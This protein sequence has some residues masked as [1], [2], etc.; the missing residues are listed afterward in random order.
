MG[1]TNKITTQPNGINASNALSILASVRQRL[2]TDP[3][4]R[5]ADVND[6]IAVYNSW[7]QH[8]HQVSDSYDGGAAAFNH[9]SYAS[10]NSPEGS[11]DASAQ[12][13]TPNVLEHYT[14]PDGIGS[15]MVLELIGAGGG[16]GGGAGSGAPNRNPTSGGGG[17]GA[18]ERKVIQIPVTAGEVIDIYVGGGGFPGGGNG[19]KRG[20]GG[21]GANGGETYIMHR[22]V[23]YSAAGGGGGEGAV[24]GWDQSGR[25][26]YGGIIGGGQGEYR[27]RGNQLSFQYT[28]AGGAGGPSQHPSG[29]WGRGGNGGRCVSVNSDRVDNYSGDWG[30]QGCVLM[31]NQSFPHLDGLGNVSNDIQVSPILT[32]VKIIN[33]VRRHTHRITDYISASTGV[34]KNFDPHVSSKPATSLP[35]TNTGISA[36]TLLQTID[37]LESLITH[38]HVFKDNY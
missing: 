4:A 18:G 8:T 28:A 36:A 17:G 21:N 26:G 14:I 16:G 9:S 37:I 29:V 23:K 24:S 1:Q 35:V 38:D 32:M 6:L 25:G 22:G 3:T 11:N 15:E 7:A 30:T 2:L 20:R 27:E 34:E 5:A 12:W 31:P 19:A 33:E 13:T 10:V